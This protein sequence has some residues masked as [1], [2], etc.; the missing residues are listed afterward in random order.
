MVFSWGGGGVGIL[1]GNSEK[2]VITGSFLGDL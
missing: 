2:S 1:Q